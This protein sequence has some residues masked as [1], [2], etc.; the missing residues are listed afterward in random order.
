MEIVASAPV[1]RWVMESSEVHEHLETSAPY[2]SLHDALL[3][4]MYFYA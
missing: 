3:M 1:E 4:K 2:I